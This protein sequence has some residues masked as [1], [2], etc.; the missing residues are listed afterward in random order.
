MS[1]TIL[2]IG[3][4]LVFSAIGASV[5]IALVLLAVAFIPKLLERLTPNIDEH[6][7]I[8]RGNRAVADYYGKVVAASILGISVVVAAAILGGL[9]SALH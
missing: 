6:K 3:W 7:E 8:A 9:L 4:S 1:P 5:G 2:N